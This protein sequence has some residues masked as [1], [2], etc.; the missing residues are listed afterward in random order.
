MLSAKPNYTGKTN[1]LSTGSLFVVC[2]IEISFSDM[3][4][5]SKK[6]FVLFVYGGH[7]SKLQ[8]TYFLFILL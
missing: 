5:V 8:T 2:F 7:E 3:I 6:C 1:L 4:D